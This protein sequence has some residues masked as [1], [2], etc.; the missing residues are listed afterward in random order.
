MR[1]SAKDTICGLR[2]AQLK[3]LFARNDFSTLRAAKKLG[4]DVR[5]ASETLIALCEAD[6]ICF[7][8]TRD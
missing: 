5:Q 1:I 7:N 3:D 8:G 6:W 4:M 2:P